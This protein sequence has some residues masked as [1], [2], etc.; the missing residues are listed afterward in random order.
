MVDGNYQITVG[1]AVGVIMPPG[2]SFD[3]VNGLI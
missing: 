1:P 3:Q 2:T